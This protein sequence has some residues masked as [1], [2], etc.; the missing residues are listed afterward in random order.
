MIVAVVGGHYALLKPPI[1]TG[2]AVELTPP[3]LE[4]RQPS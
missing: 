4:V 2:I 1:F 3:V